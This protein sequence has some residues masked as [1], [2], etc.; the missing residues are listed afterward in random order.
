MLVN[1]ELDVIDRCYHDHLYCFGEIRNFSSKGKKFRARITGTEPAGELILETE[2]G[3]TLKFGF[4]E[5][6]FN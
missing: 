5:V 4:K 2:E 6:E 3:K 1:D